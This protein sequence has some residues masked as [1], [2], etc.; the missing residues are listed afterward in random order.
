MLCKS[1]FNNMKGGRDIV[2]A[3]LVLQ[4]YPVFSIIWLPN[5]LK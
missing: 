2:G 3:A 5:F 4:D 1:H